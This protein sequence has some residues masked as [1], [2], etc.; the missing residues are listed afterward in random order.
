VGLGESQ[1]AAF[2]LRASVPAGTYHVVCDAVITDPVDVT[3]TLIW[4]RGTTDTTLAQQMQHW[5]PLPTGFRAQPNDLE[6][7]APAID[8]KPGDQLVFRYEGQ[9]MK[10]REAFI[11]TGEGASVNGRKPTITLP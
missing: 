3:L 11:P 9:S 4:R 1:E 5:E 8:W 7:A 2:T 10:L 6:M